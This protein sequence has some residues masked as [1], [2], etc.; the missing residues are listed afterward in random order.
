M[1]QDSHID[2]LRSVTARLRQLSSRS[3]SGRFQPEAER[4]REATERRR[5]AAA[6]IVGGAGAYA[7][8]KSA[9]NKITSI[10]PDGIR[11]AR[12]AIKK[13]PLRGPRILTGGALAA[14]LKKFK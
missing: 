4:Q 6:G 5:S 14:A 9:A 12:E 7:A 13:V 3:A 10:G 1:K 8:G 2:H 11:A